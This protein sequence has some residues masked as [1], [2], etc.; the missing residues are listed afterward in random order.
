MLSGDCYLG[1]PYAFHCVL[2]QDGLLFAFGFRPGNRGPSRMAL[3]Y[4]ALS[5]EGAEVNSQGREPSIL[6]AVLCPR[7]TSRG[8]A[9][10]LEGQ[11]NKAW[12]SQPQGQEHTQRERALKGRR[13]PSSVPS[14]RTGLRGRTVHLGL[15]PKALCPCC[16][17]ATTRWHIAN[18]CTRTHTTGTHQHPCGRSPF[19]SRRCRTRS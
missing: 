14:G 8:P 10:A 1:T 2:H 19:G 13:K 18:R 15:Q 11:R 6:Y 16:F 17:A 5:A 3:T 7:G 4:K 12:G 9:F